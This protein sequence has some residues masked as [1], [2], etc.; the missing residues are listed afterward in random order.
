[1]I[2]DEMLQEAIDRIDAMTLEEFRA[3]CERFGYFKLANRLI[4]EKEEGR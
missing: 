2:T 4:S 1:M 3:D